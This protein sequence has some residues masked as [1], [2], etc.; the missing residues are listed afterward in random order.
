[1]DKYF[2]IGNFI[3]DALTGNYN[4][5]NGDGGTIITYLYSTDLAVWL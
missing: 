4:V 3:V 5:V 2:A 1:M